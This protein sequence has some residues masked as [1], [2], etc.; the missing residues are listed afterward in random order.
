MID[1]EDELSI[2]EGEIAV[3]EYERD[4]MK[5]ALEDILEAQWRLAYPTDFVR[6]AVKTAQAAIAPEKEK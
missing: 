5:R 4:R 1:L 3:L 2:L 6:F